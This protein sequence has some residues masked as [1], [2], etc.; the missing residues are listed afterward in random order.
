M[1]NNNIIDY[2]KNNIKYRV[3]SIEKNNNQTFLFFDKKYEVLPTVILTDKKFILYFLI[4]GIKGWKYIYNFEVDETYK[5]NFIDKT[6]QMLYSLYD[7]S[8][9]N[10]EF[11]HIFVYGTLKRG[12]SNSYLCENS[13]TNIDATIK[14]TMFDSNFGYPILTLEGDYEI[15]GQIITIPKQQI[16][17]F[18][19]LEGYPDYYQRKQIKVDVNG[20]NYNCFI[21][22]MQKDSQILKNKKIVKEGVW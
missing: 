13:I 21:Y 7:Q 18:D 22:Y 19:Q 15:K 17:Y 20:R 4:K 8:Y 10:N 3:V 11:Y 16:F 9:I 6:N 14:G 5:Q 12:Y 2:F 1:L